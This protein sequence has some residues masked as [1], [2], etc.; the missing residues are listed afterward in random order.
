MEYH[1]RL[2]EQ[3]LTAY[4]NAFPRVLVA[5]ARQVGKS[6]LVEQLFGEQCRTFVFDPVQD[7]YG[8][9]EDP[10]LFLH[11]NPRFAVFLGLCAALTGQETNYSHLGRD[12]GLSTPATTLF[13]AAIPA[14]RR[15]S[16]CFAG[17]GQG[18]LREV[19]G[20]KGIQR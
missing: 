14:W 18:R 17:E 10:D 2:L 8:V 20:R 3:K 6:T 11:N 15:L 19:P 9:R 5:G 16:I 13:G 4:W 7:L 1:H 12:I